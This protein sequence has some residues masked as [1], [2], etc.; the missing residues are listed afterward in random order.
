M[1]NRERTKRIRVPFDKLRI[2]CNKS[3]IAA[4]LAGTTTI[5]LFVFPP[6]LQTKNPPQKCGGLL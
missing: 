4:L 1:L 3:F 6:F 2:N 5:L